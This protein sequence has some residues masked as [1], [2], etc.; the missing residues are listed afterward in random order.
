M[1]RGIEFSGLKHAHAEDEPDIDFSL[2]GYPA[3]DI[4]DD[5]KA[6]QVTIAISGHDTDGSC[7]FDTVVDLELPLARAVAAALVALADYVERSDQE[8]PDA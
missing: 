6:G 5:A 7:S 3:R 4:G 2:R 1:T 8:E